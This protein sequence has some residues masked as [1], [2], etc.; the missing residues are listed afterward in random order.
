MLQEVQEMLGFG[1]AS[2]LCIS[3][4]RW[5]KATQHTDLLRVFRTQF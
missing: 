1:V 2:G 3:R 5:P 4:V